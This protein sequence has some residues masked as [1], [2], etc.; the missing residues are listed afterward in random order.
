MQLRT[1]KRYRSG[2]KRSLVSLRWA[3]LWLLTPIVVVVGIQIYNHLDVIGPPI[4]EAIYNAFD[5][6]QNSVSTASAPTPLPTQDPSERLLRA[7][8]DWTQGRIESAVDSYQQL[9]TAVPNDVEVHY[10]LTLGLL[11]EG[12]LQKALDAAETTIT[13]NPFSADAWAI[14]CM[15]LDWNGRYGEA[16][17][18]G[19]HA[20]ELD[21]NNVR[22]MAFL[23]ESYLDNGNA[24]L[25]KSMV[26]KAH[27]GT[28]HRK[29]GSAL[30]YV[31]V[32]YC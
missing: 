11:M 6:F 31:A 2:N 7:S 8:D 9:L 27:S 24:D 26:E 15:V 1:P 19:L 21:Q 13:A 18:S 29:R 25:A 14:R 12:S 30:R 23:S 16:I 32:S 10:R 28:F 22:A 20:L 4:Q 17:A 5:G 3:W